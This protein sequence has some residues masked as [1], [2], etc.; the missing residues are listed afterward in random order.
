MK[1][2]EKR[3]ERRLAMLG[4]KNPTKNPE[5]AEKIRQDR[6][7]NPNRYWLGKKRM[8]MVGN[9]FSKGVEPW[10]K[11]KPYLQIRG[12]KHPGWKGGLRRSLGTFEYKQWRI[13]VFKRDGYMCVDCGKVGGYLEADHIKPWSLFPELRFDIN[14][15]RTLCRSC[16][17]T[18][19]NKTFKGNKYIGGDYA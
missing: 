1:S 4:D 14:N 16:H 6:L 9:Q 3:E 19:T 8:D 17:R 7:K 10:N 15:G 2:S 18:V 12:E 13:S 5:V 11:G